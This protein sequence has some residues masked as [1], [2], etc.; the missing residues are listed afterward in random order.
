MSLL[1]DIDVT[2]EDGIKITDPFYALDVQEIKLDDMFIE[3]INSLDNEKLTHYTKGFN[4]IDWYHLYNPVL[5][6]DEVKEKIIRLAWLVC[7]DIISEN[8]EFAYS[9]HPKKFNFN[10]LKEIEFGED[11]MQ[12]IGYIYFVANYK[13]SSFTK[14]MFDIIIVLPTNVTFNITITNKDLIKF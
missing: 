11:P 6:S 5:C 7:N 14:T 2:L 8:A 9:S 4:F 10:K 12:Y 13:D 1:N 3:F